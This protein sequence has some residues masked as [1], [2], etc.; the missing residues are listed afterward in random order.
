MY[1]LPRYSLSGSSAVLAP[2]NIVGTTAAGV[3]D[4]PLW[5]PS[6]VVRYCSAAHCATLLLLRFG[7]IVARLRLCLFT[8]LYKMIHGAIKTMSQ[9]QCQI[10]M[11]HRYRDFSNRISGRTQPYLLVTAADSAGKQEK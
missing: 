8:A 4:P 6:V 7:G 10:E 9:P 11:L 2:N 5:S 3:A 1:K